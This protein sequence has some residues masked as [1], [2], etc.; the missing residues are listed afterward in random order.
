MTI[1]KK[2]LELRKKANLSQEDLA[3]ELGIT[4]Q[5]ISNWELDISSPDIKQA[6]EIAIF[7]HTSLDDLTESGM[8]N[9]MVEKIS[10]TERLASLI[11]KILKIMG[12][13]FIAYIVFIIISVILFTTIKKEKTV[14]E[15]IM[16]ETTCSLNK[17]D[18]KIVIG[19]NKYFECIN[20]S[21]EMKILL[22]DVTDWENLNHGIDN[23][24][25]YF[26]ENGGSCN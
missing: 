23:I 3:Q 20:C 12:V 13:L 26:K 21:D 2:I 9:L 16:A 8:Q 4:R 25:K 11:I 15:I 24:E 6:K 19:A 17:K 10:N 1:G 14:E 7:F 18:Y 22:K 5:T